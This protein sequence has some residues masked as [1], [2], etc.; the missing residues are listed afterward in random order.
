M[1]LKLGSP[2]VVVGKNLV[3]RFASNPF[4]AAPA[5]YTRGGGAPK[6]TGISRTVKAACPELVMFSQAA[7]ECALCAELPLCC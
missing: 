7:L 1:S 5:S 2:I 4:V 6:W 3:R